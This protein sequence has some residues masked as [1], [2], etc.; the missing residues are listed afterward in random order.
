MTPEPEPVKMAGHVGVEIA[1][2]LEDG[3]MTKVKST[4]DGPISDLPA[5][6]DLLTLDARLRT[7]AVVAIPAPERNDR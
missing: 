4:H 5:L 2:S 1:F 7:L 3:R 6:L